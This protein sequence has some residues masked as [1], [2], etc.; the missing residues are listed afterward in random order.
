MSVANYSTRKLKRYYFRWLKKTWKYQAKE[1]Y[2]YC[3]GPASFT[4]V[5]RLGNGYV[6]ASAHADQAF[7]YAWAAKEELEHR[8][9]RFK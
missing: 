2:E 1:P 8:G 5:D 6:R 9:F 4:W 7:R 3:K